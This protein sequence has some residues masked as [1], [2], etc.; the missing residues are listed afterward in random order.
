M[1]M[2]L[3]S[4]RNEVLLKWNMIGLEM[5]HHICWY[6][7]M[8]MFFL[9]FFSVYREVFLLWLLS[10]KNWFVRIKKNWNPEVALILNATLKTF[11][12]TKRHRNT[13]YK[14]PS[15]YYSIEINWKTKLR[16]PFFKRGAIDTLSFSIT[17]YNDS[18]PTM[19][20]VFFTPSSSSSC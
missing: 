14:A 6:H 18:E 2:C 16:K 5:E 7:R 10:F 4:S 12:R 8:I 15:N 3:F 13:F 20:H 17:I 11:R 19:L 1:P 9:D